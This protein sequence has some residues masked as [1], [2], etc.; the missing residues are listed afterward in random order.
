MKRI[1]SPCLDVIRLIQ[2]TFAFLACAGGPAL[3][4]PSMISLL[5]NGPTS[6]RINIVILS[7]GYRDSELAQF[8]TDATNTL[9]ALFSN[10]PL[11]GYQE[12]FNAFAI[13]V[14][15]TESG[16]DHP[17]RGIYRDTYFQTSYDVSGI[18]RYLTVL[19]RQPVYNI[20]FQFVPNF[21]LVVILVNDEEY[22]GSGGR[23]MTISKHS[24]S[25][26][27][28]RHE[29]GHAFAALGDEYTTGESS[30]SE[31]P[32][33]TQITD[34][35]QTR[36]KAWIDNSTAIPTPDGNSAVGL[37]SGAHY[38]GP[39]WYRPKSNCKMRSLGVDYCE[40]CKEAI[41]KAIYARSGPMSG[42]EPSA[43]LA[44]LVAASSQSFKVKTRS[45]PN[46]SVKTHWILNGT[47][48]P[49]TGTNLV[50]SG[51]QLRV[52]VNTLQVDVVDETSVVRSDPDGL[53]KNSYT[54]Q[55]VLDAPALPP[56]Q[57]RLANPVRLGDGRVVFSVEGTAAN[58]F[59]I[60]SSSN[61][62]NWTSLG[63]LG[64]L[65]G[66]VSITNSQASE[67]ITVFRAV[68]L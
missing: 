38:S 3:A 25:A 17:S 53:L 61:L 51:S 33:A 14:A 49:N 1:W 36:W 39:G 24:L 2:I 58:G 66:S 9:N 19:Q 10:S 48:L 15:S 29:L 21:D 41:V 54:W 68:G 7:E 47:P 40:I 62:V 23:F 31:L 57:L 34:R 16:S 52:G 12:H 37:F 32:N 63:T 65:D 26:E 50:L 67:T 55:V 64:S 60:E 22:G 13:S 45:S 59:R 20:L 46:Q 5:P 35:S 18:N 11:D 42:Q 27:I 6:E 56:T 8:R 43:F 30:G 44:N 28:A 4:Q